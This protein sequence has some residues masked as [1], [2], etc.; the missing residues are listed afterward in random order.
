MTGTPRKPSLIGG[1]TIKATIFSLSRTNLR[2]CSTRKSHTL[3]TDLIQEATQATT[4]ETR[5]ILKTKMTMAMRRHRTSSESA[6]SPRALW[7]RVGRITMLVARIATCMIRSI[8]V[9]TGASPKKAGIAGARRQAI[10]TCLLNSRFQATHSSD[11]A[12]SI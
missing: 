5:T 11:L 7:D 10:S 8:R 12:T 9:L 4:T 1:P 6:F 2:K 3:T